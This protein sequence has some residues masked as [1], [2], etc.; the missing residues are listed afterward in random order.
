M[1]NKQLFTGGEELW[2]KE[3]A[4]WGIKGELLRLKIEILELSGGSK[5]MSRIFRE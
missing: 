4:L 5:G 3:R 2:I 1:I